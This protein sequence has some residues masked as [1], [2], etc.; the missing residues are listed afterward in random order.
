[1]SSVNQI[2]VDLHG[3]DVIYS[4]LKRCLEC[5]DLPGKLRDLVQP[6]LDS[7]STIPF[8]TLY[9]CHSWL[10]C[11]QENPGPLWR[12]FAS[13][14]VVLPAPKEPI[15]NADLDK[16]VKALREKFSNQAYDKMVEGIG[17]KLAL[18]NSMKGS[19][20]N[21][22]LCSELKCL[23]KQM[24]MVLNFIVVV[25]AGFVFGYFIPDML[26]SN[27]DISMATRL[28]CGLS[29]SLLIFFADLYFLI[30]NVSEA[31]KIH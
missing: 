22:S 3:N 14:T 31:E 29:V 9:E 19:E 11:R 20:T 25:S 23:N 30:K 7:K 13:T 24:V 6:I 16:R 10:R 21:S 17:P 4:F 8:V 5:D 26:S 2:A 12:L 15:R 27:L 1:M 18:S 28:M